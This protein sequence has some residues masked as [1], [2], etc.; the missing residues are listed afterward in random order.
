MRLLK[1][2]EIRNDD[3]VYIFNEK[4]EFLVITKSGFYASYKDFDSAFN[5]YDFIIDNNRV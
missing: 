4:D 2:D 3:V 1:R 5:R